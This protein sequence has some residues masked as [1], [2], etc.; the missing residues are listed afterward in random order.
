[1]GTRIQKRV[2]VKTVA[3]SVFLASSLAVTLHSFAAGN[4]KPPKDA[5]VYTLYSTNY[6]QSAGRSGV[7][8]FDLNTELFN[9][10]MCEDAAD[11][12]K[13]DFE[14]LKASSKYD[15]TTKMRYWCEK[16]RFRP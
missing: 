10:A 8:T 14:R 7:A 4:Q 13:A 11:L 5:D 2:F 9:R 6:P 16:G 3:T 1:M 12:Y 15:G